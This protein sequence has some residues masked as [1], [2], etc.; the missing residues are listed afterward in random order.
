MAD[1]SRRLS[2][3]PIDLPRGKRL[4]TLDDARAY[5]TS[6]RVPNSIEHKQLLATAIKATLGAADGT[7]FVMHARIAVSRW[8]HRNDPPQEFD[9]T[10]KSPNWGKRKLKRDR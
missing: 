7:D 6:Q 4:I 5:L 1:W 10:R 3:A 2:P 9:T 8:V